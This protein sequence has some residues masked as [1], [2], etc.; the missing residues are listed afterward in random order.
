VIGAAAQ[1]GFVRVFFDLPIA[2]CSCHQ[3]TGSGLPVAQ[4]AGLRCLAA[5]TW[6]AYAT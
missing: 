3:G 2:L 4:T 1:I 6:L 5:G